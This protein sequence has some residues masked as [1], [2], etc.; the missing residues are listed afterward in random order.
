MKL[1]EKF[2]LTGIALL[3]AAIAYACMRV[4]DSISG[5]AIP[6]Q[7]VIFP[8]LIL[9][10]LGVFVRTCTDR[11]GMPDGRGIFPSIKAL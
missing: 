3:L 4:A 5:T 8:S 11:R 9:V 10:L 1:S 6:L 2:I 7:L